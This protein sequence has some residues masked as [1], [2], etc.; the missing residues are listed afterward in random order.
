[1]VCMGERRSFSTTVFIPGHLGAEHDS[2]LQILISPV[3]P[4]HLNH[5]WKSA[6]T[7]EPPKWITGDP[8][9]T[10]SKKE[11]PFL[12]LYIFRPAPPSHPHHQIKKWK[13]NN[14]YNYRVVFVLCTNPTAQS[15]V[16]TGL[17][18]SEQFCNTSGHLSFWSFGLD[19]KTT[20]ARKLLGECWH[21]SRPVHSPKLW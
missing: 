18:L 8:L 1:M 19:N 12:Y 16:D 15:K 13:S 9:S 6:Q 11:P 17:K 10:S 20:G 7:S 14:V 5:L 21:P 4:V 3:Q 2:H